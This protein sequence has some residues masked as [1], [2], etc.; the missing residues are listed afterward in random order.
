[1]IERKDQEEEGDKGEKIQG[2]SD[3]E[4]KDRIRQTER[5][6]VRVKTECV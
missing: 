5:E 2:K 6:R 1:M 3:N 4:I